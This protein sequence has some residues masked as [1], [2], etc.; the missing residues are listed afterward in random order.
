MGEYTRVG[1][2]ASKVVALIGALIAVRDSITLILTAEV[3]SIIF[4]IIGIIL[5][6]IL[7][8]AMNIFDANIRKNIPFEWWL[9]LLVGGVMLIFSIMLGMSNLFLPAILILIACLVEIVCERKDYIASK[10][11]ILIGS[12]WS[13][14]VAFGML[15]SGDVLTI[16]T[17]V[18]GLTCAV[19]L[20]LSLFPKLSSKIPYAWWFIL[21][22]GFIIF[23]WIDIIGGTIIM[24][25]W[26]LFLMAY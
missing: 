25:G 4:G 11:V 17:G 1:T 5:A 14:I 7:F 19:L 10:I 18:V 3:L 9:L 21:I 26:I 24:V 2:S 12:I 8:I 20:L 13:I 15:S 22:L 16:I 23:T 6:I